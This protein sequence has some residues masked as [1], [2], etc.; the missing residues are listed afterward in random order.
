MWVIEGDVA[1]FANPQRAQIDGRRPQGLLVAAALGIEVGSVP[2]K[3]MDFA[4][5]DDLHEMGLQPA[6]QAAAVRLREINVFVHMKNFEPRPIQ[7]WNFDQRGHK[8]LLGIPG[9]HD[10]PGVAV[11]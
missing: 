5:V 4:G 3:V 6:F 9:R 11:L 8:I 2:I 7:V 1:I 10:Q